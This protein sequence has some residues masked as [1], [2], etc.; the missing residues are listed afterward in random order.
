MEEDEIKEYSKLFK[1][2]E[3]IKKALN[4]EST[5]TALLLLIYQ[6]LDEIRRYN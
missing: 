2:T 6:K 4:I 5:D 3:E 1:K